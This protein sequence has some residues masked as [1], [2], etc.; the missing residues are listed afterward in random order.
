MKKPMKIQIITIDGIKTNESFV[1]NKLNSPESFADYDINVINLSNTSVWEYNGG[2]ATH[3]NCHQDIES[4]VKMLKIT[5]SNALIILPQNVT[6]RYYQSNARFHCSEQLKDIYPLI[7]KY[8]DLFNETNNYKNWII[9]NKTKTQIANKEIKSDF[10]FSGIGESQIVTKSI[11]GNYT[12]TFKYKNKFFTTLDLSKNNYES[13]IPYFEK[14]GWLKKDEAIPLWVKEEKYFND[15][16]LIENQNKIETEINN[17][18]TQLEENSKLL[19]DNNFYKSILYKSGSELVD[20]VNIML[21]D[22]VGY[23]Y[24]SFVDI[25]NEDFLIEKE[26]YVFIGEIKGINTNVKRANIS[27]VNVH[28]DFYLDEHPDCNK[29]VVPVAIINRLRDIPLKDRE[30]V[31]DDVIKLAKLNNVLLIAS[32]VFLKL[33]ESFKMGLLDS[34]QILNIFTSKKGLLE[35]KDFT[36]E[37]K[38]S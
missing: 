36:Q 33:Y 32:E 21:D 7:G 13:L 5:K 16:E 29:E 1:F 10:V 6:Y 23:D 26:A 37:S 38:E 8:I 30:K 9:Y 28:K 27:Q 19:E 11:N 35:Y 25:N 4:M 14:I 17:L 18:K 24:N 34:E 12:T 20:V 3:I 22:M 15:N 2:D 31:N